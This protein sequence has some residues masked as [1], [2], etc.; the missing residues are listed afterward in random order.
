MNYSLQ[1]QNHSEPGSRPQTIAELVCWLEANYT[2]SVSLNQLC[3][4]T[5]L[6]KNYLCRAFKLHTSKTIIE[7]INELRIEHA[8]RELSKGEKS[9]TTVAFACGFNDFS[10][11]SR[12]FKRY[13]GIA[14]GAYKKGTLQQP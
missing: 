13:K 8:C 5:R 4:M 7:Y 10:Y 2:E 14:P 9:V 11:F 12:M 3:A 1:Q 6:S